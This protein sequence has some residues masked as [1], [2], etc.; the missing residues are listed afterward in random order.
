MST[1]FPKNIPTERKNHGHVPL[2]PDLILAGI[3]ILTLWVWD[4]ILMFMFAFAMSL[5]LA[6]ISQRQTVLAMRAHEK[7]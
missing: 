2:T 1:R 6:Y 7:V 5:Y 4:E 3:E